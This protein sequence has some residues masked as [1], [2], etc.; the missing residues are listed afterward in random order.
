MN[1]INFKSLVAIVAAALVA[2]TTTYVAQQPELNRLRAENRDLAAQVGSITAERD[3]SIA[4]AAQSSTELE[5]LRQDKTELL[6]LRGEIGQLRTQ[7][8]ELARLKTENS[9]LRARSAAQNSRIAAQDQVVRLRETELNICVNN[10]R[11]I[12]GA[13]QQCALEHNLTVTNVVTAEQIL[14]Y[15]PNHQLLRCP[16]G[17]IYTFG[18]LTNPPTCSIPGHVLQ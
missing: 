1:W 10:L 15:L 8:S 7:M 14:P 13:M 9:E 2:G 3:A 12:D 4:A 17:G 11:Q 18:S 16:S 6:R 5:Q